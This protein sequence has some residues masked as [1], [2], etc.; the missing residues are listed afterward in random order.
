MAKVLTLNLQF[1][2][3]TEKEL[4]APLTADRLPS[5]FETEVLQLNGFVF[6]G[7][8]VALDSIWEGE[9]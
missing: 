4:T 3:T 2:K 1:G 6:D 8:H 5:Y 9:E 7:S